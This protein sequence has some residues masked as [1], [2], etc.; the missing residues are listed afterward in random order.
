[1]SD[2]AR[3]ESDLDPGRANLQPLSTAM[4]ALSTMYFYM[5]RYHILVELGKVV[6]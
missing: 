3:P 1:M 2:L 6:A 5:V 4:F